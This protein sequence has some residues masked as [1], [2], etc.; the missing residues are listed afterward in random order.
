MSTKSTLSLLVTGILLI[1]AS[2][3]NANGYTF[4]DLGTLGGDSSFANAINNAGQVVGMAEIIGGPYG[5]YRAALWSGNA[6]TELGIIGS[7]YRSEATGINDA[8]QIVGAVDGQAILWNGMIRSPIGTPGSSNF[9]YDINNKGEV[10]GWTY[11]EGKVNAARWDG[12]TVTDLQGQLDGTKSSYA[13]AINDASQVAGATLT[14]DGVTHAT[15][16]NGTTAT[17]LGTLNGRSSEA[18]AINNVGQVA[19]WSET[20]DHSRNAT[21]WNG[22][23]ATE[24]GTLAGRSS[25]ARAIND[26]G[27]VVG[28]MGG[29][30]MLWYGTKAT[31]LN[32]VL[33]A[34]THA[35]WQLSEA[36]GINNQGWIVGDAYTFPSLQ[37]IHAFLLIPDPG[38]SPANPLMPIIDLPGSGWQFQFA[39]P[40]SPIWIDPLVATGYDYILDSGQNFTSVILPSIGDGQ[41][42]LYQWN[43][44]DWVF[45]STVNAGVEHVFDGPGVDRFR[46]VGIETSAGLDPQ[47][48]T[49]FVTGLTFGGTGDASMRMVPLTQEV[50]VIPEPQTY[51]MLL[52]GLGLVGFIVRSRKTA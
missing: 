25:E 15:V 20:V 48:P 23:T 13:Y 19:G 29:N 52:A 49:A 42:S 34:S 31:D 43:G 1:S 12:S 28:Y 27:Q 47:S 32:S 6:V 4:V 37:K 8:G 46:I 45:D 44:T 26:V 41:F 30:A 5:N 40:H 16:W 33:D 38:V 24:L 18:Y 36:K 17:N 14:A 10:A 3:A 21:L 22:T 11:R 7:V 9:V 35:G 2:S 51:A 50:G 39:I